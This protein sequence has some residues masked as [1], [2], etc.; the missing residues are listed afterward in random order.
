M[1]KIILLILCMSLVLA[2]CLQEREIAD[3]DSKLN[4][5]DIIKI[6]Y[7]NDVNHLDEKVLIDMVM[8]EMGNYA[9]K[10][11]VEIKLTE[12]R[13][14]EMS[15]E[16]YILKRNVAVS[17]GDADIVIDTAGGLYSIRNQ[18][19][20]YSKLDTY[21]NII[22]NF[23]GQYCIPL[24][25]YN[26]ASFVDKTPFQKYGVQVDDVMTYQEYY[27]AKQ[28]MKENGAKFCLN[29]YEM[30]ELEEY[31]IAKN[32]V[33]IIE[34]NGEYEINKEAV[35]KTVSDIC[36]DLNR[37]YSEIDEAE[38]ESVTD[39][40]IRDEVGGYLIR[41]LK[42][43][44][45]FQITEYDSVVDNI[46]YNKSGLS[47]YFFLMREIGRNDYTP[48]LFI[49]KNTE[50]KHVYNIAAV[51]FDYPFFEKLNSGTSFGPIIDTKAVRE[52]L[53]VDENWKYNGSEK[54]DF[55]GNV[56]EKGV[57]L[58]NECY[59]MFRTE[60]VSVLFTEKEYRSLLPNFIHD[61]VIETLKNPSYADSF[62]KR[63]DDFITN[64]NIRYN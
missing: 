34:N 24:L 14:D 17:S 13:S 62:E 21:N 51:L 35:K 27:E 58:F 48:S 40:E 32:D 50:R 43:S 5:E 10:N 6:W 12:Y 31:Y 45:F 7:Y 29:K 57:R 44:Q 37:Y 4:P 39:T 25:L 26:M 64:V 33:K 42:R 63:A 47:D 28:K 16:N 1:K 46:M 19:G 23:K 15:Y 38:L 20:D 55:G 9:K 59:E 3:G 61:E 41:D 11:N 60:D 52:Y 8:L 18:H 36:G 56:D 54:L 2:S 49:N 53:H 30:K 22:E